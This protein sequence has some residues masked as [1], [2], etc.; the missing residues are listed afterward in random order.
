MT[1]VD[2]VDIFTYPAYKHIILDSLRFCQAKK[3]LQIHSWCLMS[4]HIHLIASQA[5]AD[6]TLSG[7]IRDFKHFT[8]NATIGEIQSGHESR[9]EWL[10]HRFRRAAAFHDKTLNFKFWQD[11]YEPKEIHTNHF[12]QQKI[13]YIH[14]N[15]VKAEMVDEPQHYL[16]SSA[17]DYAGMKGLL[18]IVFAD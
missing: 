18:D 2:W 7:V 12:L 11:G 17:R 16:Y 8:S 5:R 14:E 4:N 13:D 6:K 10:L 9:R 3:G 15:P 1:V